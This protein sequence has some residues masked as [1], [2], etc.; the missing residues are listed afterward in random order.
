[1]KGGDDYV[2]FVRFEIVLYNHVCILSSEGYEFLVPRSVAFQCDMIQRMCQGMS[3]ISRHCYGI[4][5]HLSKDKPKKSLFQLLV[6]LFWR[7]RSST[8]FTSIDTQEQ[9]EFLVPNKY[10]AAHVQ[11]YLR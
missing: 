7:E 5:D 6:L 11:E 9:S 1:M 2:K 3:K 4:Q 8:F 10:G